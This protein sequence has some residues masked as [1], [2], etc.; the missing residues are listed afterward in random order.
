MT[1]LTPE[2]LRERAGF[3]AEIFGTAP[4]RVERWH[5]IGTALYNHFA[6][7]DATE[8]TE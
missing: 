5:E 1:D 2:A 7:L 8:A 3:I 6:A 4:T